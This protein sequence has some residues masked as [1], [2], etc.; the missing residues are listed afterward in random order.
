[1][2]NRKQNDLMINM[3][4][5]LNRI[6]LKGTE[7]LVMPLSDIKHVIYSP[8]EVMIIIQLQTRSNYTIITKLNY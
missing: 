3:S 2:E 5:K 1:M 8:V 6:D 4:G 7:I